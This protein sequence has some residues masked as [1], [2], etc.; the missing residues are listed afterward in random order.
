MS[1]DQ[2]SDTLT[3][4]AVPSV[5]SEAVKTARELLPEAWAR[6]VANGP[7]V[8]TAEDREAM[9]RERA[10]KEA[11]RLRRWA[12]CE[13]ARLQETVGCRYA[14][15]SFDT[16]KV[17]SRKQKAVLDALLGYAKDFPARYRGGT[18]IVLFGPSGT[19][20]DHLL[21]GLAR[22]A[23]T[24]HHTKVRWQSGQELYSA[25][26]DAMK[27][28]YPEGD[29]LS[30]YLGASVLLLSD[31]LPPRGELTE[32]QAASL[33]RVIDYRYRNLKPTWVTLNVASGE[34]AEKRMGVQVVDRLRHGA[35]SL[36]C[37]W[38]SFRK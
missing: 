37:S 18:N 38:P 10:A 21:L 25:L 26:R 36:H 32:Y 30:P 35:L 34:E 6:F 23:I 4:R 17:N 16:F 7:R 13:R 14:H 5:S 19:G 31:P 24:E 8:P 1:Q 29:V 2:A 20:K 22:V 27:E 9:E 3:T 33:F 15:C 12:A 11:E 28:D